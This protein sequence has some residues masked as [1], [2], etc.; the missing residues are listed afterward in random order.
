MCTEESEVGKIASS[1]GKAMLVS[2]YFIEVCK[3]SQPH[4]LGEQAV[5]VLEDAD[6]DT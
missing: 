3:R 5:S 4:W 1:Q 2:K 6:M